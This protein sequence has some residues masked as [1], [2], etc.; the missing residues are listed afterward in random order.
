VLAIP[1]WMLIRLRSNPFYPYLA[2]RVQAFVADG[3]A[4]APAEVAASPPPGR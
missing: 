1:T 4:P 3:L 2:M